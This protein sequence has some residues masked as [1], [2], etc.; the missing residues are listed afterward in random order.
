MENKLNINK[1]DRS[2]TKKGA[3]KRKNVKLKE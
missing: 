1:K 3:I 2:V